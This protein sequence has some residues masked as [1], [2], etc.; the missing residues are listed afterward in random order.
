MEIAAD[1]G[2]AL[3]YSPAGEAAVGAGAADEQVLQ[4]RV[5][6]HQLKMLVHHADAE[7]QRVG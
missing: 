7:I 5:A 1:G 6:R 4:N 2:E 3:D